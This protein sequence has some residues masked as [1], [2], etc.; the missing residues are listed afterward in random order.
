MKVVFCDHCG[1]QFEE[2]QHLVSAVP[3]CFNLTKEDEMFEKTKT[4]CFTVK[5]TYDG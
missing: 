5:S 2:H 1:M 3:R 4:H